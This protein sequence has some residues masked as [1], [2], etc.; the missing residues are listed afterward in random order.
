MLFQCLLEFLSRRLRKFRHPTLNPRGRGSNASYSRFFLPGMDCFFYLKMTP[1][2]VP[3][4]K[5]VDSTLNPRGRGSNAS[6]S[7]FCLPGMDCFFYLKMTPHT[8]PGSKK[9]DSWK[10]FKARGNCSRHFLF[11]ELA[12]ICVYFEEKAAY[13][14]VLMLE[15]HKIFIKD[16]NQ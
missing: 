6:Y 7:R 4:S 1:H 12:S 2:T 8:V 16:E 5:K 9:V 3:G 14:V 15:D 11:K 10:Q 13:C